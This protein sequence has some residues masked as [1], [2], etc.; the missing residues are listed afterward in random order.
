MKTY[1]IY[2]A[3]LFSLVLLSSCK[4]SELI[5]FKGENSLYFSKSSVDSVSINFTL[6]SDE[7][8]DTLLK[9][10]VGLLGAQLAADAAYNVIVDDKITTA[11]R[12]VDFQLPEQ[13]NFLAKRSTDTVR[14]KIF[15]TEKLSKSQHIIS[16][17]LPSNPTFNNSLM[18]INNAKNRSRTVRVFVTD[19]LA[20]PMY[21]SS[22]ADF[23][24]TE[25][26]LGRFT[27]KKLQLCV[28]LFGGTFTFKQVYDLAY[29]LGD[30][31]GEQLNAHL[32]EQKANGTP[33]L[34][35][36][37]TPMEIGEYYK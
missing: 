32:Q 27:K 35:D 22:T 28:E 5:T 2:F 16:L 23:F 25:Y 11:V 31:F 14:V 3:L 34:E 33:V 10:P 6:L 17:E 29:V 1:P 18:D 12:G 36:D 20:P 19:V 37:G 13:F 4:K 21:W 15:R 9:I 7:V 8:K 30:I 26:F 24:G